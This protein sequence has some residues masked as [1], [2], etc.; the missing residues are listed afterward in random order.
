MKAV[1]GSA[2]KLQYHCSLQRALCHHRREWKDVDFSVFSFRLRHTSSLSARPT[3]P[4]EEERGTLRLT[5]TFYLPFKDKISEPTVRWVPREALQENQKYINAQS[6]FKVIQE[7][8]K[9]PAASTSRMN[10]GINILLGVF[11]SRGQRCRCEHCQY[12]SHLCSHPGHCG[13]HGYRGHCGDPDHDS[14]VHTPLSP[15]EKQQNTQRKNETNTSWKLTAWHSR[16]YP[17]LIHL[18]VGWRVIPP[19]QK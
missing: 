15:A 1:P 6:R 2:R 8:A 14:A 18:C 13:H 17:M 12:Q 7:N 16:L 19:A 3:T 9:T 11:I 10:Q 4:P 5:K